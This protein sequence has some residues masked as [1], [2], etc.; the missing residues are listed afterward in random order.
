MFGRKLYLHHHSYQYLNR[1]RLLAKLLFAICGK[2]AVHIV[3]CKKMACDLKRLYPVATEIQIISGIAALESWNCEAPHRNQIRSIG[4]L[5][6]ISI[7]KGILEFLEVAAWADRARLPLCFLLAGPF[8]DEKVRRFV[9]ERVAALNNVSRIGAVYGGD[10]RAFFDSIDVFLFPTSY[11]DESEGLVIH[12]A[13]S[14]GVP[15]I[16]YSRG[17]IE[18]I[19]T[20]QVGLQMAPT[21]D[22]VAGTVEKIKEWYSNPQAFQLA[23]QAA[24]R[25]FCQARSLHMK[26]MNALCAELAGQ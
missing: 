9:E 12:E 24:A 13:M 3:A 26:Q 2:R 14:R 20:D 17:C 7:E 16:A 4:F 22:F 19:V 8:Q 10:K 5:S 25:R 15:V 11:A 6:N 18:E 23:S 21:E 1:F